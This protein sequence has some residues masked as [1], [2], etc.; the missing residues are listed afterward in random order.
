MKKKFLSWMLVLALLISFTVPTTIAT[1]ATVEATWTISGDNTTYRGTLSDAFSAAANN[2]SSIVNITLQSDISVD[3]DY[4]FS[5]G[6]ATLNLNSF[7]IT[8][9]NSSSSALAFYVSG[10]GLTITGSGIISAVILG[11][12]GNVTLNGDDSLIINGDILYNGYSARTFRMYG[13][14]VNGF[15]NFGHGTASISGGKINSA[16]EHALSIGSD[17]SVSLSGGTFSSVSGAAIEIVNNQTGEQE[18]DY[19]SY[20]AVLVNGY[21]YTIDGTSAVTDGSILSTATTVSV[22]ADSW[23]VT[24]KNEDGTV[25]ETDTGVKYGTTPSYDGEAPTKAADAQYTYTFVGWTPEVSDVTGNVTYTA[26]YSSTD[27]TY[28]VEWVDEDGT[29]LETD[30]DVAYG[31][32]PSYDGATPMKAADAYYTYTFAGWMPEVS[33]VTGNVTYT[34]TY[35]STVNTYAVEWVDED[36]TILETDT[37]V[38][39]G[40]TPSYNGETPIK[41]ADAQYTYTFAGWTPMVSDVT[42]NVVYTATYSSTVNT[43]TVEWVDE[44]GTVLEADT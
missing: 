15:L 44:D 1:A 7:S 33:D 26:T 34:A 35:S 38:A 12:G 28:S 16:D 40:T 13:G 32:T 31:T 11:R 27:N 43:Y 23:T 22:V 19:N 42:G 5:D 2:S 25:L 39:Y 14:T 41:A 9:L 6:N 3:S 20:S 17:S 36:G 18:S 4:V 10:G 21:L 29:V 37:D 8:R 30:T 24:W